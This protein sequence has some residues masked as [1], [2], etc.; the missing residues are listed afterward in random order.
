MKITRFYTLL[1]ALLLMGGWE[2][3]AQQVKVE[4]SE[5]IELMS[6]MARTAGFREYHM[7]MAGKMASLPN[8]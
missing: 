6:I 4:A 5:T 2:M 1:A 7:D 8:K 3:Q